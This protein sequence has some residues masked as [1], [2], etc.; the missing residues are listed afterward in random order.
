MKTLSPITVGEYTVS[1][2]IEDH[3]QQSLLFTAT[4]GETKWTG[5]MTLDVQHDH[6]IEQFQKDVADFANRMA[7]EAAGR[8]HGRKLKESLRG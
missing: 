3:G 2:T 1:I 8:E 4:C 7:N 6:S 5:S